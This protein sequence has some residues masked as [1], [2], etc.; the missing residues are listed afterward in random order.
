MD[1]FLD[2]VKGFHDGMTKEM[3][4]VNRAHVSFDHSM[5]M[6]HRF[7]ARLLVQ[8]Q[9][10]PFAIEIVFI[11][12]Q[13]LRMGDPGEYWDATG[14]VERTTRPVEKRTVSLKFD[15]GLEITAERLLVR[16]RSN[17]LGPTARLGSEVPHP[18]C[19][20]A[21]AILDRW[22]QCSA[23]ADAFDTEPSAIYAVCPTC[24][25]MTELAV[26]ETEGGNPG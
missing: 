9:W 5:S 4:V 3:Y 17:W 10:D 19:V 12:V 13:T 23:C 11:G 14:L 22:R 24:G 8:T 1:A 18:D 21:T 15:R 16:D 2:H 6:T 20:P 7:D 26:R 25:R